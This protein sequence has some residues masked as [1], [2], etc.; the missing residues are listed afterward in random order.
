VVDAG[1]YREL[2]EA[3]WSWVFGQVRG[4]D[5]PWL[6]D[7]VA[8]AV[9]EGPAEDRDSLYAGIAGLAPLLV[10]IGQYRALSEAEQALAAGIVTRL[11]RMAAVRTDASL[12][13]GLAGDLTALRLLAP[14]GEQIALRRL[15]SLG[16]VGPGSYCDVVKGTAG[17]MMAA[18]WAGGDVAAE[19]LSA[20]G[21]SLLRAAEQTEA[22]LDWR[23]RPDYP[24]SS[25]N[26]SHGTAGVASALAIAGHRLGRGDFLDAARRGADHLL[27][28]AWLED[29]GFV[30]PHT[31]PYSKRE[32]EPVTYTWCHGPAG[33]SQFFAALAFVGVEQV[34]QFEVGALRRRCL[35]SF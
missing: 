16:P 21:E 31:L 19:I 29:G 13:D 14:G 6:P 32:V 22:G 23:M 5:G 33:T 3:A 30:V 28:V 9:G 18:A 1:G 24:S 7:A 26:F 27:S 12:Y 34:G 20:G 2:G 15:A 10:E 11:S 25:P 4:D 35:H 8:D 17:V